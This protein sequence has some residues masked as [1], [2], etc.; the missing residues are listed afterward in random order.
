MF[1]ISSWAFSPAWRD[2]ELCPSSRELFVLAR[3]FTDLLFEIAVLERRRSRLQLIL[4]IE[5]HEGV[6]NDYVPL[7][8][9]RVMMSVLL[10][11]PVVPTSRGAATL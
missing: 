7:G 2:G 8:V 3:F 11:G 10:P 6:R 4:A 9:S 5:F 1:C